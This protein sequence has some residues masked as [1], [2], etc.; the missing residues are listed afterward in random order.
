MEVMMSMRF[1]IIVEQRVERV[2]IGRIWLGGVDDLRIEKR[3]AE[4]ITKPVPQKKS[5]NF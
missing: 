2:C 1:R 3:L 5:F 4:H